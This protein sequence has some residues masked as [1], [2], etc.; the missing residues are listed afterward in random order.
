MSNLA[1]NRAR[2][3]SPDEGSGT[4]IAAA[5]IVEDGS[6]QFAHAPEG[7]PPDALVGNLGEEAF[8]Q[9]QPRSAG[10]GE[11][12]VIAGVCRKPCFDGRMS[13]RG[14]VVQD[15]VNC[16]PTG[17]AALD[18]LQKAQKLLV[19]MARHAAP[20]HLA[21][22]YVESGE[23]RR[24]PMAR[25]IVALPLRGS[26]THGQNRL[27][28]VQGLNLALLIHAQHQGLRRRIQVQTDDV[29]QL[30]EEL[31]IGA[32]FETL[33]PVRLQA[34]R[35]PPPVDRRRA[36]PLGSG[37]RAHAPMRGSRRPAVEGGVH[38]RLF[39]F[40]RQPSLAPRS[41]RIFQQSL[42]PRLLKTLPP[43]Q[44]RRSAG[45]QFH[46]QAMVRH[47]LRRAQHNAEAKYNLWRRAS[48]PRETFQQ[49]PLFTTET[50]RFGSFPH[51]YPLYCESYLLS[52]YL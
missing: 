41:R 31:G 47:S 15:Q 50:Q 21:V 43:A 48:R 27:G 10:G 20:Q 39:F 14:I 49:F 51:S 13:V 17:R 12:P 25:V 52:R 38:N 23:H 40:C 22:Q 34:M 16:Q 36:H 32:E 1:S 6:N 46:G 33:Y 8:H 26:R 7:S 29:V 2:G 30:V 5:D 9:V 42:Q 19:A 24:G 45:A 11:V 3:S 37:Q 28:T 4:A 44:D 35:L 18:A